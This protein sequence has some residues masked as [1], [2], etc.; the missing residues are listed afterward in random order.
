MEQEETLD[1]WVT[2]DLQEGQVLG[3]PH[4]NW[5]TS[6]FG[7]RD[8]WPQTCGQTNTHTHSQ[9]EFHADWQ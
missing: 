5:P 2:T 8:I 3:A 7:F 6:S 9:T 1:T 4:S